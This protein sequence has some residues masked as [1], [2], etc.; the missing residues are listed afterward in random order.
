MRDYIDLASSAFFSPSMLAKHKVVGSTPITR[1]IFKPLITQGLFIVSRWADSSRLPA[2]T[3]RVH[4]GFTFLDRFL[5]IF[6]LRLAVPCRQA[7]KTLLL[8]FNL[9]RAPVRPGTR[10]GTKSGQNYL[11]D[12]K[13]SKYLLEEDQQGPD[14]CLGRRGNLNTEA[15]FS[16]ETVG[17]DGRVSGREVKGASRSGVSE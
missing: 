12:Q 1:S 9:S 2:C 6:S 16:E 4:V 3:F 5:D 7:F 15:E 17:R 8:N 13:F 14:S 11:R 10:Q